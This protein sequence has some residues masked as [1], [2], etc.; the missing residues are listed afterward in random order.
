[1]D[2]NMATVD[3]SGHDIVV[4]RMAIDSEIEV[5]KN[6]IKVDVARRGAGPGSKLSVDKCLRDLQR[7]AAKLD[8]ALED[9][10]L[11]LES[12]GA[13]HDEET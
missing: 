10:G 6:L 2:S 7:L 3:L 12:G 8:R 9:L 5:W 11:S 13:C 1:M 4:L